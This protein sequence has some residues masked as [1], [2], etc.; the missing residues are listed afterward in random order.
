MIARSLAC[1]SLLAIGVAAGAP[2]HAGP[3]EQP[4]RLVALDSGQPDPATDARVA[5]FDRF[6]REKV[7]EGDFPGIAVAIVDNGRLS[8]VKGY[9]RRS[10][11]GG[12]VD[13]Q[14]IF[15][16]AS[17]SKAFA[18]SLT[19]L[20]VKEQ[21]VDWSTPVRQ[22]LPKVSLGPAR[23]N[24]TVGDLLSHRVGLPPNAYDDLLE[25]GVPPAEIV[26]RLSKL[27]LSCPPGS[28]YGYQ[29][30]AFSLVAPILEARTGVPYPELVQRRIFTPLHMNRA[31]IGMSGL[32]R[33]DNWA[34]PH[35]RIGPGRW[36]EV[37]VKEP[38]YGVPAAAGVNASVRDM[39]KWLMAQLGMAPNV[40]PKDV[41]ET[42]HK[43]RVNTPK[44]LYRGRPR[45]ERLKSARYGYGWRIYD[46]NDVEVVWHA[47]SVQGYIT[48][49]ALVPGQKS[50]VVFLANGY[51]QAFSTLLPA[52][53]ETFIDGI[54]TRGL[55]LNGFPEKSP[56]RSAVASRS[57]E[58]PAAGGE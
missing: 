6:L 16:L 58:A 43:P 20:M 13:D 25:A 41:L 55:V 50:G 27:P 31:S 38:Y 14:T 49:I 22:V 33:D 23:N 21:Y 30:V 2:A 17:L 24:V 8:L 29:N 32:K 9:G 36:R 47:G 18:S 5:A 57:N 45:Y 39:A 10:L 12:K 44:E 37:T 54:K 42:V 3:A 15:R 46:I 1:A 26:S 56:S 51:S 7:A 53:L 4:P 35:V 48:Q 34:H 19:G 52:Y 28:C 11:N 40:L